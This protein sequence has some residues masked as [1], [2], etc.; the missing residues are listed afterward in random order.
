MKEA[1]LLVVVA[2]CATV[3]APTVQAQD[4]APGVDSMTSYNSLSASIGYAQAKQRA[5]QARAREGRTSRTRKYRSARRIRTTRYAR[6][7][8]RSRLS[9]RIVR[10]TTYRVRR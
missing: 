6:S 9:P 5:S 10:R 3:C 2:L 1:L 4:F 8:R 7:T